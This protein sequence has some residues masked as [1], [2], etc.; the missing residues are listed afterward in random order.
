[1][2]MRKYAGSQFIKFADVAN[3][4]RRA[5]IVD[6]TIGDFGKPVLDL[7]TGEKLSTNATNV[8][9]L[10]RA[11]GEDSQDWVQREVEL[12]AGTTNY[13]GEITNSVLIRPIETAF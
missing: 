9:T 5:V 8:K 6:V 2:K 3:A 12:Y 10:I 11:Y 13:K 7:N 4:P 1:M